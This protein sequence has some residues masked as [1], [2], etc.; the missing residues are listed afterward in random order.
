MIQKQGVSS[1]PIILFKRRYGY[2]LVEGWHRTMQNLKAYPQGY[3][4]LAWVGYL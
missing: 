4:G 3:K 2:E 1:E